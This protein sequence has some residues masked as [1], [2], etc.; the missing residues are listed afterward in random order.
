MKSVNALWSMALLL[1]AATSAN[2]GEKLIHH[3]I[4]LDAQGKLLSWIDEQSPY[5]RVMQLAWDA[6]KR[7]PVQENGLKTYLT[8]PRF[9]ASRDR[10]FS[11]IWWAHN[12]AG[13]TAMLTES[14]AAY[15]AYSGDATTLTLARELVDYQLAHGTT[16]ADWDWASVPF[17]SADPGALEWRGADD[18]KICGNN[19]PCGRGDG[20]GIIEPDKVG[21][22]GLAYLRFYE[23]TGEK[24]YLDAALAC[25]R[26]LARHIRVGDERRSPWPFRVDARSGGLVR[27][28]YSANVIGP[29]RLFD[30]L[31]ADGFATEPELKRARWIA[32]G[33]LMR[34]PMHN[35]N[36]Q[37]YFEDI[38]IHRDP[39]ENPNQYS[40]L[41]TARYLLEHPE[42]DPEWRAH[43][44]GLIDFV[45]RT[46]AVDVQNR[47]GT[48]KGVEYGAEVIS[49]QRD[50]M[51]KMGSHTARFASVLA[52]YHS[53][54][55]DDDALERAFRSFN[56]ATYACDRDGVVKVGP[57]DDEG[58]WFS[59]GY[60]DYMRH[61]LAGLAAVP[62]WAP[63]GENHLLSS[64]STVKVIT[65]SRDRIAYR[66]YAAD[67]EDVFRL[68][69]WPAAVRGG[70]FTVSSLERGSG[71]LVRVRHSGSHS[72]AIIFGRGR[73]PAASADADGEILDASG[74]V[75]L[76]HSGTK[77]D[78]KKGGAFSYGD[79]LKG[80]AGASAVVKI[81]EE[82][83]AAQGPFELV[84]EKPASGSP[85]AQ[86]QLLQGKLRMLVKSA[87]AP[88]G[89]VVIRT[90]NAQMGVRGTDF[91]ASYEGLLG[92]TEIISFANTV[93]FSAKGAN[94]V[95]VD[96]GHWG[97]IGG[98]F[99][100]EIKPPM[101]LP[102]NV[103]DHFKRLL[104]L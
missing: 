45:A 27:E 22:V 91:F 86:L 29:I 75:A 4:R 38:P 53:R 30:R 32:W 92:E 26:A 87:L 42:L 56:W 99:G 7:V 98:R 61:F 59:D 49:E 35:N 103:L 20:V 77:A 83:V 17:A 5:H 63:A 52:L 71:Y 85:L 90:P 48:E 100:R 81:G 33:W 9:E 58:Y 51:A 55:G 95:A 37:G 6:L 79:K 1:L 21:E 104:P 40:P 39:G 3:Q 67:A 11:G 70:T 13:L 64:S 24:S 84:I 66:T 46:F 60:A 88:R 69:S 80:D 102:P 101:K 50:D 14:A 34:Y 19:D 94:S 57:N 54:T 28:E 97:G 65:Y 36:W 43:A 47:F 68:A 18:R 2:A 41:E 73:A 96:A 74:A 10:L 16:P 15:Y 78:A 89:A 82:K 93:D 72:V 8:Y 76:E 25:A 31:E 23:L 62:R 12:P 44:K